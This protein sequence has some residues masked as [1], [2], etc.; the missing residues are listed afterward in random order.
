[1]VGTWTCPPGP[2]QSFER[3]VFVLSSDG[4]FYIDMQ[5]GD[6]ELFLPEQYLGL[7]TLEGNTLKMYE[8][9]NDRHFTYQISDFDGQHFTLSTQQ[10]GGPWYYTKTG[11]QGL[12]NDIR[13]QI[14]SW[15]NYRKLGGTWRSE[16]STIKVLPYAGLLLI[17]NNAN[18]SF[19]NWGA[20][21]V[22]GNKLSLTEISAG[23]EV[24]YTATIQNFNRKGFTFLTPDGKREH[25]QYIGI[26]ELDSNEA[27]MVQ[28]Y[29]SITHRTNMNIID[30]MDGQQ[31]FI[32]KWVDEH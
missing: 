24:F 29:L 3:E 13:Q 16:E 11:N 12:S 22:N 31:D 23:Q 7:Y 5:Y 25:F 17:R 26:A 30:A 28:N 15:E 9:T 6:S 32:W 4:Y 14:T 19:F 2:G 10:E 27:M 8:L 20:Y 1:M 21:E 18:R